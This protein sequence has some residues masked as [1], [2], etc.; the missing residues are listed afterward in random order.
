M[1]EKVNR[2]IFDLDN[3]L[4]KHNFE[5]ANSDVI[6]IL[7]IR[8]VPEFGEQFKNMFMEH[9]K[10]LKKGIVSKEAVI[11][12]IERCMP[13]LEEE[14]LTGEDILNVIHQTGEG[15][16]MPGAEELLEYLYDK[17]Y[18][19]VAL[20]NWFFHHQMKLLKKLGINQYFERIYA[21][22][23]YYA[24]PNRYAILRALDKTEASENVLIG[25]DP[26]GDI[27]GAKTY[28][29]NAIAYNI[30]YSKYKGNKKIKMPDIN[31]SNLAEIKY[32][33]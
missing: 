5:G 17:G 12:V 25:D 10:Y 32:Y 33:L 31:V 15:S 29:I 7:G 6:N 26:I 13:I 19:I 24:K 11:E 14:K 16:L 21:W 30:D 18:Q 1:L 2:V 20:T 22:D 3:T 4:I 23:N 8:N 28:G 9:G 27:T